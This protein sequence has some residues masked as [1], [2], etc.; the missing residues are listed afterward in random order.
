MT[1]EKNPW[2]LCKAA[3][4]PDGVTVLTKIDDA[5]GCRNIQPLWKQG[6]LWFAQSDLYVYY[7]PTHWKL[8]ELTP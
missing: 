6:R 3:M 1:D 5:D 8:M 7:E 4:P 2:I